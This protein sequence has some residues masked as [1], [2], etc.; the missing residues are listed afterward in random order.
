[1][2]IPLEDIW[3]LPA[4]NPETVK[5]AM[6]SP[7]QAYWLRAMED[8]WS[9]LGFNRSF[10]ILDKDGIPFNIKAIPSRWVFRVK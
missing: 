10:R 8:E 6:D 1:M 2:Q 9:S 3:E 4:E 5:E 7:H